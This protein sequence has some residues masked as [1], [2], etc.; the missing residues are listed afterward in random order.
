MGTVLMVL[1]LFVSVLLSACCQTALTPLGVTG[2]IST[3]QVVQPC[4]TLRTSLKQSWT[5]PWSSWRGGLCTALLITVT[6]AMTV[7]VANLLSK[8][9][10]HHKVGIQ[11]HLGQHATAV[12]S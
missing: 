12:L 2:L 4:Q 11:T 1:F 9:E 5:S 3:L 7:A 6:V 8:A 10:Q